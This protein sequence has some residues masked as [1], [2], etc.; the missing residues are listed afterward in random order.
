MCTGI[1]WR[2]HGD[3]AGNTDFD[4][5]VRNLLPQPIRARYVRFVV[6]EWNTRPALRAALLTCSSTGTDYVGIDA[7]VC[8]AMAL[9]LLWFALVAP[10]RG[11]LSPI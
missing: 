9:W 10:T 2:D 4:T 5:P 7:G 11:C 6:Q 3:F 8:C 1:T